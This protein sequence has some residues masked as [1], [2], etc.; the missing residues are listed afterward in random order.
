MRRVPV[1]LAFVFVA[2]AISGSTQDAKTRK[3]ACRTAENA[4]TCYWTHGRLSLY[5]GGSPNFR[6]WK[7]GTHRLL[8]I[9][10]GPG[11]GSFNDGLPEE[12]EE[13][14]EMPGNLM[15]LD[16]TSVYVFGDFE[17]CPL[18]PEKNQHMQPACI[19]S[20]KNIVTKKH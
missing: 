12:A 6:L 19:E 13:A 10:S 4:K 20:A 5:N 2:S 11:V 18:A 16:F 17:V 15:D 8:G 9:Y 14:V 7:I 3:I 1:L